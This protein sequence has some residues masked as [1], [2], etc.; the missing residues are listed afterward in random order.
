M[1]V[2][3]VLDL[4]MIPNVCVWLGVGGG[5]GRTVTSNWS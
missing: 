4:Q 3:V 1:S 2:C 5:N